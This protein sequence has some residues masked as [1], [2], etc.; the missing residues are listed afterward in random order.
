MKKETVS[1]PT[2]KRMKVWRTYLNN[3]LPLRKVMRKKKLRTT[4]ASQSI[5]RARAM[6]W[7]LQC[8]SSSWSRS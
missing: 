2:H 4:P 1:T 8:A 7:R 3:R 6:I 5:S